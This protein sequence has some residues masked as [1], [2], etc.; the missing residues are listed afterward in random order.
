MSGGVVVVVGSGTDVGKTFV[1]CRL[2]ADLRRAGRRVAPRKPV[3]SGFVDD[4]DSDPARLIDAAGLP[5]AV[6]P[7]VSPWRFPAPIAPDAAAAAV[8]VTLSLD[9]IVAAAHDDD[10][11]DGGADDEAVTVVETAGGVMSPL[12]PATTQL[13]LVRR[14]VAR[15]PA[16]TVAVLVVDGRYLGCISHGLTAAAVLRTVVAPA[17]IVVVVNRGDGEPFVR[18]L[19]DLVVLDGGARDAISSAV[20][21]RIPGSS[22]ASRS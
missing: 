16:A 2:L 5:R 9:D 13:D 10:H 8:G 3:V 6:L 14:L 12:T 18:F 17:Q 21:A 15:A 11:D 4:D 22:A 7:R 1:T 20:A 19:P